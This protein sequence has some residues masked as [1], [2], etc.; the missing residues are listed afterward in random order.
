VVVYTLAVVLNE[1]VPTWH[2]NDADRAME[3]VDRSALDCKRFGSS[4]RHYILRVHSSYSVQ[5]LG[6]KYRLCK[7]LFYMILRLLD[8]SVY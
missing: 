5:A 7:F 1:L 6:V 8:L 3:K 2:D 4:F